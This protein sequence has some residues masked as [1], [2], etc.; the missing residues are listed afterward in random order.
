MQ[1]TC[2][3]T[4]LPDYYSL[5]HYSGTFK[6]KKLHYHDSYELVIL[7]NGHRTY[8]IED[9]LIYLKSRDVLLINPNEIH[10]DAGGNY[11][12]TNLA[13]KESYFDKFFSK[14]GKALVVK[15]FENRLIRINESDFP[16]LLTYAEKL[17]ADHEDIYSLMNIMCILE[18]N[19]SEKTNDF[20]N[21]GTRISGV[22]D[23]INKNYATINTLDDICNALY[24]SKPYLCDL[25][26]DNTGMTVMKYIV[27]IRIRNSLELL[28]KTNNSIDDVAKKCGFNSTSY[29]SKVFK[30]ITGMSPAQYKRIITVNHNIIT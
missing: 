26:K 8:V 10:G 20:Q 21:S 1:D 17:S 23:Y 3:V 18:S 16:R 22:L 24:I 6:M 15:C 14:Y 2:K 30:S 29:F 19:I 7:E 27:N 9:K 11:T 28:S 12:F 25:F 4:E 5:V 13:F